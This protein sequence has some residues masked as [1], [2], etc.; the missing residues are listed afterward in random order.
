MESILGGAILLA[1]FS[2]VALLNVSEAKRRS[3]LS[4][5]EREAEDNEDRRQAGSW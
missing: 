4:K 2:M 5:S 1:F 3:R